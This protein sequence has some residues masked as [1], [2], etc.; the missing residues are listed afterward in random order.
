MKYPVL[1]LIILALVGCATSPI[2]PQPVVQ[3]PPSHEPGRVL[4]SDEM[5]QVKSIESSPK[6]DRM[7]K[8]IHMVNPQY[9]F[10]LRRQHIQATILVQFVIGPDGRVVS[11]KAISSP[12][13]LFSRAA[14]TAVLEWRF[15]PGEKNGQKAYIRTEVPITFSLD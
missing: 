14:E 6:L 2:R 4:A 1:I 5:P 7:P 3:H 11:A 8:P 9:P 15:E 10:E 12:H 13:P